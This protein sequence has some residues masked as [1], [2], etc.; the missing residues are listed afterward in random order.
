MILDRLPKISVVVPTRNRP[1]ELA[2]LLQTILNQD[3]LPLEVIIVD[4]SPK[5]SAKNV[6]GLYSLNFKLQPIDLKFRLYKRCGF[7]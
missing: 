2:K 1:K 5:N 3:Y 4:D 6:A 7:I